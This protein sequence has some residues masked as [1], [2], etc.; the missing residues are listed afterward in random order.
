M[1]VMRVRETGGWALNEGDACAGLVDLPNIESLVL[2]QALLK[3]VWSVALGQNT[4]SRLV[5]PE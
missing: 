2:I 5:K 3:L 1:K 4:L